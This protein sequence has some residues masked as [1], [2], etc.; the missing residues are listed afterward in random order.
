MLFSV[1]YAAWSCLIALP[2]ST[3]ASATSYYAKAPGGPLGEGRS[4]LK[5]PKLMPE[6][7]QE[8]APNPAVIAM[9]DKAK[10]YLTRGFICVL[11]RF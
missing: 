5:K 9:M 7:E 4:T 10:G 2:A 11:L 6:P 1:R 8:A 3:T